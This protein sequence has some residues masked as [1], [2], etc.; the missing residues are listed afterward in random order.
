MFSI[1][2][3]EQP[4]ES[5]ATDTSSSSS[6]SSDD[7]YFSANSCLGS[8]TSNQP[9]APSAKSY[10]S[11]PS[12]IRTMSHS[13]TVSHTPAA[14]HLFKPSHTRNTSRPSHAT[15]PPIHKLP[16]IP[17]DQNTWIIKYLHIKNNYQTIQDRFKI[18]GTL[19]KANSSALVFFQE[20]YPH[21]ELDLASITFRGIKIYYY[22]NYNKSDGGAMSAWIE[23]CSDT[24]VCKV[25]RYR[26]G[27]GLIDVRTLISVVGS[28]EVLRRAR[29][30]MEEF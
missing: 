7:T 23:P 26:L 10:S 20:E 28:V 1:L 17:A 4:L 19:Q 3:D 2:D 9:F 25:G 5:G 24:A 16:R 22:K 29:A 12:R 18:N 14:R 27:E 21:P 11:H 8:E 30:E 15:I 6:S 13:N